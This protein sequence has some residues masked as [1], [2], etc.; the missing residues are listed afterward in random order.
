[1]NEARLANNALR[2]SAE[3]WFRMPR[4]CA[5]A[6]LNVDLPH[7]INSFNISERLGSLI[8]LN[9]L[10]DLSLVLSRPARPFSLR[11]PTTHRDVY[12]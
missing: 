6:G 7:K 4:H 2:C 5:Q 10:E 3:Q 9:R 11:S 12:R 1:M 8:E